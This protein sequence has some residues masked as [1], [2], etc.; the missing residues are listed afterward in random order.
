MILQKTTGFE[1]ALELLGKNTNSGVFG[2]DSVW[3]EHKQ[4]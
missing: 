2:G 4:G 1:E 3:G